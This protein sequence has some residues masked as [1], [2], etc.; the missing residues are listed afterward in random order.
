MK[1]D[2]RSA[3]THHKYRSISDILFNLICYRMD[4]NEAHMERK[5][6]KMQLLSLLCCIFVR[7][8]T[9]IRVEDA[10]VWCACTTKVV[11]ELF[12]AVLVCRY[13]PS[14]SP[15]P[16]TGSNNGRANSTELISPNVELGF[17]YTP[18]HI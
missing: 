18:S 1:N 2:L 6:N 9:R 14:I 8:Q 3:E 5:C 4:C 7:W 17:I 10:I 11:V 12:G 15:S 16:N 13:F